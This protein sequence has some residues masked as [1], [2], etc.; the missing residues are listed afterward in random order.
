METSV[1]ELITSGS[2]LNNGLLVLINIKEVMTDT[3]IHCEVGIRREHCFH[4][5]AIL[6]RRLWRNVILRRHH[7]RVHP[8]HRNQEVVPF[9]ITLRR[10]SQPFVII[11]IQIVTNLPYLLD[12]LVVD[13]VRHTL[14]LEKQ[15]DLLKSG[16][17]SVFQNKRLYNLKQSL[18]SIL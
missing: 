15:T 17:L 12:D 4:L 11:C 6:M 10:L 1:E 2:S 8:I 14:L 9:R 7:I 3:V 13:S 16:F 18:Q 5:L